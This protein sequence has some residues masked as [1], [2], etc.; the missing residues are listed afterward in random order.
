L[1]IFVWEYVTAGG[2]R[3]IGASPSLIA[4]GRMMVR[5]LAGDLASVPGIEV[6]VARDRDI[7]L[8]PMP[9]IVETVPPGRLWHDGR[10][11]TAACDAVW[12][13]APET[14]GLLE[15]ATRLVV[16]AQR[17]V[18]NSRLDALAVARSKHATARCLAAHG[19]PTAPTVFLGETPPQAAQ[20]WVVKPDDGAGAAHTYLV[21]DPADLADRHLSHPPPSPTLSLKGRDGIQSAGARRIIQPFL[22]GTPLSLSLLAQNGV[23]WLLACNRQFVACPSGVFAYLGGVVGGAEPRR[24]ALE[25]LVARIARA[26]PGLWGYVGVDLIDTPEG[27]VVLEINPRLTTSYVGLRASIGAN[28]AELVLGLLDRP[29]AAARREL[30]PRPVEIA[31]PTP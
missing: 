5:A 18:L 31:V 30:A 26:L 23:A 16:R 15:E 11:L 13:I 27:P 9:A 22:P 17:P 28:P 1:R 3:E 4:E 7:D 12:P 10:R 29:L 6:I 2:W 8:G 21:A 14:S 19:V 20:G 24:A 25:P